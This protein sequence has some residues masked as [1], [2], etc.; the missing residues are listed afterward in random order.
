MPPSRR[1]P[2]EG[3]VRGQDEE[4]SEL[5]T[6]SLRDG[7]RLDCTFVPFAC[8]G[9]STERRPKVLTSC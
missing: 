9:S 8:A 1:F 4:D 2:C 6:F 7:R 3:L 5:G